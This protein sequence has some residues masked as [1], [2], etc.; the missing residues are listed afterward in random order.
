MPCDQ[1]SM[2]C[3]SSNDLYSVYTL[4]RLRFAC[5]KLQS[6]RHCWCDK[7]VRLNKVNLVLMHNSSYLHKMCRKSIVPGATKKTIHI[8]PQELEKQE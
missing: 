2:F 5:I 3:G 7:H 1:S 6:F 4:A 8:F